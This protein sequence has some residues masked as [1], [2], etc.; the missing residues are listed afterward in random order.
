M[1]NKSNKAGLF[2]VAAVWLSL[3][4]WCYVKPADKFSLSERRVLAQFP[5]AS[6]DKIENGS[7]MT[8][9]E[10]YTLDQFPARDQFRTLK[11][12]SSLYVF[13]KRDNNGIYIANGYASK[14]EYPLNEKSVVNA[15]DKITKL[16]DRYMKGTNSKVYISIV[17]DKNYFLAKPNG[18][19]S[20]DY[21]RIF[22][23]IKENT[24]YAQ[25]IDIT[26]TLDIDDY[27]RTDTHWRQENIIGAADRITEAM[28][29][30]R[31]TGYY[32]KET[33]TR[34]YGVYSGQ[35]ALPLE[36]ESINYITSD[37]I[38]ECRVLADNITEQKEYYGMYD[39]DKLSGRDPY[40]MYLSGAVP[41]VYIYNP[42]A[43]EEKELIV[44]RDSF[45]S[46]LIPLLSQGYS[47]ITVFD[48]RYMQPD[49]V[50]EFAEF[51]NADVLF[52][53]S[54]LL[55]NQSAAMRDFTK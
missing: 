33:G 52:V 7:F 34:F 32:T 21:E 40:E 15:A 29:S 26:D 55:I 27:Y 10:S 45:G 24:P 39:M 2:V 23:L 53:Y 43:E 18:Y 54:T 5:Q 47:K 3:S 49:F 20:M 6:L 17:P 25:Y 28:G 46:S 9:F 48:T 31:L 30:S 14:L 42:N 12:V 8:E 16:Y 36:S 38:A 51:E 44:F 35:S 4:V 11:S 50:G 1:T 19:L 22:S 41:V 37:M 13:G